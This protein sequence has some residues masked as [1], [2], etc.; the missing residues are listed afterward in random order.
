M[1]K[2][3]SMGR[4]KI[5]IAK[6]PKKNHLQVTFSKR[7]SGLFK[8][9]SELCT[10]CGVEVAIIVFSPAN[11]A[12]SFGHPEVDTVVDRFVA[13]RTKPSESALSAQILEAHRNCSI[14]DLNFV[15]S[16]LLNQAEFERK[17]GEE[18]E[19]LRRANWTKVWW[20][21]PI[22]GLGLGELEQLKMALEEVRRDVVEQSNHLASEQVN[23]T[24]LFGV[25]NHG[26]MQSQ[27]CEEIPETK[28]LDINGSGPPT[29]YLDFHRNNGIF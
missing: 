2:K 8:K 15:L 28:P 19:I 9:A 13:P 22:E 6:I 1:A 24:A 29:F 5:A 17:K 21:S 3:S 20:E 16:Q 23:G 27:N 7:R 11:K 12:F 25:N 14:R 10:L 4:Q 18:I 26:S